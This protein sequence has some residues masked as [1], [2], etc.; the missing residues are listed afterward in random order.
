MCF[1]WGFVIPVTVVDIYNK[2]KRVKGG[3]RWRWR[4]RWRGSA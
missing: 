4:W 1:G 2:K 3:W